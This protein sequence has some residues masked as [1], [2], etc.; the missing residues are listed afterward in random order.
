[1]PMT[2]LKLA[3]LLTAAIACGLPLGCG[4]EGS[5]DATTV[6]VEAHVPPKVPAELTGFGRWLA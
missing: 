6:S 1:M 2:A 4:G 3:L 5:T